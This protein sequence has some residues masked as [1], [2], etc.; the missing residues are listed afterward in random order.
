MNFLDIT[1]KKDLEIENM[2]RMEYLNELFDYL[3]NPVQNLL[4]AS[5]MLGNS[6]EEKILKRNIDKVV[7]ILREENLEKRGL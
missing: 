7:E 6:E 2:R 4:F 3:R 1:D 5:Y